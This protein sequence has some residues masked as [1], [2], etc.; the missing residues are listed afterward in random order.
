M[1]SVKGAL[2]LQ[3]DLLDARAPGADH[4]LTTYSYAAVPGVPHTVELRNVTLL[5]HGDDPS[6]R[7][8]DAQSAGSGDVVTVTARDS[9]VSNFGS[10]ALSRTGERH[11]EPVA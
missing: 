2:K 3:D 9:V 6:S 7:G 8:L 11:N 1:D 10:R 5:G 4:G